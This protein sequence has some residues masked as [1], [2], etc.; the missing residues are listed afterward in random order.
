MKKTAKNIKAYWDKQAK[1]YGADARATTNDYWFRELE[2]N[3]LIA[4]LQKIKSKNHVLDI[5]CGNGFNTMRL[6]RKF[7]RSRFLGGDYAEAMI[8]K[9]NL[10]L[11]QANPP[12]SNVK[13]ATMD[14]TKLSDLARKFDV[15]I[16][17]RCLINLPNLWQ[18]KTAVAEIVGV[19]KRGGYYVMI[20][21][22]IE[23]HRNINKLRSG[24]GLSPIAIKWHNTFFSECFVSDW[25]ERFFMVECREN[26]SSLYYLITRA[27]YSKICQLK[28]R[29]PDYDHAIYQVAAKL[30][31]QAGDWG[32]IKLLVLKKKL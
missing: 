32:P 7:P 18:Q 2:F 15:V 22:F 11:S 28:N 10:A 5:G 24:I 6:A 3:K 23:G 27:V 17:D 31:E 14:V 19:I 9:S 8:E 16:S 21:N 1:L 4:V 30:S 25:I 29:T 13:F 20:E 26:I 12:V